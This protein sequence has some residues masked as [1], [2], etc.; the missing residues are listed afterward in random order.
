MMALSKKILDKV[1]TKTKSDPKMN[2][3]LAEL[4]NFENTRD[5]KG[6]YDTEYVN[7]LEKYLDLKG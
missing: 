5:G 3:L 4:I 2:S 7:L 1:Q 6:G